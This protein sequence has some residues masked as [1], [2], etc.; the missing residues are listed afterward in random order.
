MQGISLI[1]GL[2]NPGR[3]HE[4]HRHNAGAMF[5]A[6][7]CGQYRADLKEDKKFSGMAGTASIAGKEVRLIFPTTY[8]NNS[9]QAV[10]AI[11]SY[12]KIPPQEILVAY[13]ELDL[14]LGITRLKAGGGAGGHNG[15][16][17][18]VAALGSQDFIRLRLGIGH[19]G[20]KDKVTSHVLN[21]FTRAEAELMEKEIDKALE[22]VPM[23]VEGKLEAAMLKLHT[24]EKP[25]GL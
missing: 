8:M 4:Q 5:L 21:N 22:I 14:P 23:L 16:R 17:D 11:A 6:S 19:P 24:K 13:D 12:F 18:I 15:I 7:L 25:D 10:G 9:G 1:A 3:Q 2:G 20:S